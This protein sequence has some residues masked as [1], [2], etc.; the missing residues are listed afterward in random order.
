[1]LFAPLLS[2]CLCVSLLILHP[3]LSVMSCID[4]DRI[5]NN[6]GLA[7]RRALVQIALVA[8]QQVE[9]EQKTLVA[10]PAP[11]PPKKKRK[12]VAVPSQSKP[13]KRKVVLPF[14]NEHS[15]ALSNRLPAQTV[16]K[17]VEFGGSN[18]SWTCNR[19]SRLVPLTKNKYLPRFP[20]PWSDWDPDD[21]KQELKAVRIRVYPTKEQK[22]TLSE[23]FGVC[24][25]TY[26]QVADAI[27]NKSVFAN[28]KAMRAAF[29][30]NDNFKEQNTFVKDVPYAIRDEAM[31][32]ALKALKSWQAKKKE[33]QKG[34]FHLKF[35]SRSDPV[36]TMTAL[37]KQ[38]GLRS[39]LLS[40]VFSSTVLKSY[41]KRYPLPIE[42]PHDSRFIR[43]KNKR[44]FLCM[45][46]DRENR[47]RPC[48]RK[49]VAI[50]PGV[51]TF[52]TTYDQDGEVHEWGK[53][54]RTLLYKLAIHVDRLNKK[55]AKAKHA[56]RRRIKKAIG[57]IYDRIRNL[58]DDVHKKAAKWL[59]ENHELILIPAFESQA[60]TK[61][62]ERRIHSKTVRSMMHWSH[63]RFRQRLLFKA[64]EYVVDVRV[65]TEEYTSKTCGVCGV[66]HQHLGG[67]KHFKCPS[68]KWSCDRDING[69]RNILLKY[70]SEKDAGLI[71]STR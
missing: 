17:S 30:N 59:C 48:T 69:A 11:P 24:R 2:T 39:G 65:V 58:V 32:D 5:V 10:P 9:E 15:E 60:M 50:D 21:W 7:L 53:G 12:P 61:K 31:N 14:W 35:R 18:R 55:A 33:N 47:E 25:W 19:E 64:T 22:K 45:P 43:D 71:V 41:N 13:K 38:W 49:V 68:C 54:D 1:V 8:V 67:S 40:K 27:N 52:I 42:L 46:I 23:W 62:G 34:G 3:V 26:N 63:Y 4:V 44:Y 36:Q 37:K 20:L 57:R 56:S 28:K 51:R 16:A 66:I 70:L 29:V 6:I